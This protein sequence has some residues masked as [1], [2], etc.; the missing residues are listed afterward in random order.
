MSDLSKS[1]G[2]QNRYILWCNAHQQKRMYG[3]CLFLKDAFDNERLKPDAGHPQGD[4]AT[5]MLK[6]NCVAIK[7]REEELAACKSLYFTEAQIRTERIVRQ[8][9]IEDNE[10]FQRGWNQV[11]RS[12]GKEAPV[13]VKSKSVAKRIDAQTKPKE[14]GF[15]SIKTVDMAQLITTE[16][17]KENDKSLKRERILELKREIVKIAK[18]EKERARELLAEVKQLEV[19]MAV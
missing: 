16:V 5:A 18:T 15:L 13:Q 7:M 4:C 12:L 17:G 3:V 1:V 10:S 19:E 11:G 6:G 14:E 2:G 8:G 9:D